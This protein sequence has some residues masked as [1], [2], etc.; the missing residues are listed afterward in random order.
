MYRPLS[1]MSGSV[2]RIDWTLPRTFGGK[3]AT[4]EHILMLMAC[5]EICD[6]IL[7]KRHG[8]CERGGLTQRV[9]SEP[10]KLRIRDGTDRHGNG[11]NVA[12]TPGNGAPVCLP[13][14][15]IGLRRSWEA[16]QMAAPCSKQR[17]DSTPT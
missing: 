13:G 5:A 11:L 9:S 2:P 6:T 4:P 16:S 14:A 15:G 17:N 12:Q 7:R 8:R 1:G 3:H 10:A